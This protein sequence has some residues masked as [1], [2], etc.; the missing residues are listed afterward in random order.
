MR[1]LPS[2]RSVLQ[3]IELISKRFPFQALKRTFDGTVRAAVLT[4]WSVLEGLETGL[5]KSGKF[6]S[7]ARRIDDF[8][9][10][11]FPRILIKVDKFLLAVRRLQ[12]NGIFS[13]ETCHEFYHAYL[14]A[15]EPVWDILHVIGREILQLL[16][17]LMMI[18]H[19]IYDNVTDISLRFCKIFFPGELCQSVI[20]LVQELD[21][22]GSRQLWKFVNELQD[23]AKWIQDHLFDEELHSVEI[24]K[25][26]H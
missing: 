18:R 10:S 5:V 4:A 22:F 16:K 23:A 19:I 13:S 20:R 21:V 9:E 15:V 12:C 8:M 7:L 14:K 3:L 25:A 1:M 6:T 17:L 11:S 26:I 24:E 2:I